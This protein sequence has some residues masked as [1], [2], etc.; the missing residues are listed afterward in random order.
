MA[1]RHSQIGVKVFDPQV[2]YGAFL[3]GP[4]IPCRDGPRNLFFSMCD[5]LLTSSGA[6]GMVRC[7]RRGERRFR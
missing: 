3:H 4:T 6:R 1:Y 7:R 5:F 2:G